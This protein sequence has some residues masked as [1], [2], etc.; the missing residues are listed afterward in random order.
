VELF[1]PCISYVRLI[2]DL[3]N[4]KKISETLKELRK[5]LKNYEV[6]YKKYGEYLKNNCDSV[7]KL[8]EE[9]FPPPPPP[10]GHPG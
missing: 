1:I 10:P 3:K 5:F 8:G 4:M 2:G 7:K 9:N 6:F